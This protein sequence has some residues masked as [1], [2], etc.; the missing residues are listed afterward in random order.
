MTR[1]PW[2]SPAS[3]RAREPFADLSACISVWLTLPL[4][5]PSLGTLTRPDLS[6]PDRLRL[7]SRPGKGPASL[8]STA[9]P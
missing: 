9:T 2:R 5:N 4:V 1:H 7:A 3:Q 8:T 6:R